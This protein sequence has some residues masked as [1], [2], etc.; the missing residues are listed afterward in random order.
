MMMEDIRLT[1]RDRKPMNELKLYCT[2]RSECGTFGNDNAPTSN[3]GIGS[4]RE[5]QDDS[6]TSVIIAPRLKLRNTFMRCYV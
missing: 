5:R 6:V 3:R 2:R 4:A 1:S